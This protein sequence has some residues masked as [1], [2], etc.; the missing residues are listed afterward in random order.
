MIGKVIIGKSFRGCLAYCLTDKKILQQGRVEELK[1]GRVQLL[2]HNQCCGKAKE[3]STQ[4]EEVRRLNPRQSRPVFHITLSMAPGEHLGRSDLLNLVEACA[5]HMGFE[6]NQ[7]VAVEHLDTKHQHLHIVANRVGYD[8]R[9]VSDSNSYQRIAGFCRRMEKE[10]GLQQVLS[11]KKFLPKQLRNLPRNDARK[12]V[13]REHLK[14]QLLSAPAYPAFQRA[15]NGLGYR[16]EKGRGIAFIDE[17][18][19]RIKGSEVGYPLARIERVLSQK[20]SGFFLKKKEGIS[21]A[22]LSPLQQKSMTHSNEQQAGTTKELLYALLKAQ[23]DDEQIPS[24]LLPQKR[25][26]KQKQKRTRL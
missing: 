26:Q 16:V 1:K 22:A 9:V 25:K 8:G 5:K 24:G 12:K 10:L 3:L 11:P 7:Y 14:K 6:N 15:M 23:Q 21:S 19:V 2:D 4:F 20:Q 13:L 18:G 17:K